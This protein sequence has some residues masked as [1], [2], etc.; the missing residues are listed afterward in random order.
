MLSYEDLELHI[1]K[2]VKISVFNGSDLIVTTYGKLSY[3]GSVYKV[4]ITDEYMT[5][6]G[7]GSVRFDVTK[8]R[9]V[10]GPEELHLIYEL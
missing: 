8:T 4:Y 3:V 9:I 5:L 2:F 10:E 7:L 1:E 6:G